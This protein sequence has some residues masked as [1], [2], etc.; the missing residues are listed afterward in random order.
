MELKPK[1]YI[2]LF[3]VL[4]AVLIGIQGYQLYNTY[5]LKQRDLYATTKKILG[6]LSDEDQV[7]DNDLLSKDIARD[8]YIKVVKKEITPEYLKNLYAANSKKTSPALTKYVDSIFQ[9][10]GMQVILKKEI[11]GIYFKNINKEIVA[12]PIPVYQTKGTFRNPV[13]LSS[14][15]WI[16][17]KTEVQ[18]LKDSI[19]SREVLYTFFVHR[20]SSFEVTNLHW[21]LFKEL[22]SLLLTTLFILAAFIW[23]F[24]KTIKNL[25]KQDKQ[26]A[27]LHDVVDNISHELKT[28]IATLKIAAKTLRK[29]PNEEI[30]TVIERQVIRLE[31]TLGPLH[32][33][34]TATD[35]T[36]IRPDELQ[37]LFSDFQLANPS[38][39]LQVSPLLQKPLCLSEIDAATL[40]HNLMNN[41]AKYGATRLKIN[42]EE[43]QNTI[44]IIIEDNGPGMEQNELPFIFQ[45]FYR[46][47]KNNIHDTK[48]LGIGLFL[49]KNIVV[50]YDGVIQVTS[51]LHQGTTFVI[52]LPLN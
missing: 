36:P 5:K 10:L 6:K 43:H 13:E 2:F 51:I 50:K 35:L 16:T 30:I 45:K 48:G 47:Q 49:V 15:D 37:L 25:R 44:C 34:Q 8:Y 14:S 23:L 42:F 32:E 21:V 3:S 29:F 22:T 17:E 28:P 19:Q 12:G 11:F 24:Y 27:V 9:P 18:K 33:K 40:F 39:Q 38:V 20:K 4:F 41:A 52:H 26:I 31:Q 46:I 7:F 1:N